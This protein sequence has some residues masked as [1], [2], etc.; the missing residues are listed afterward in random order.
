MRTEFLA[1]NTKK[2]AQKLAPWAELVVK[3]TG[4][5]RAFES[6]EDYKTFKNQK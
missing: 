4:G 6:Q 1:V 2:A 3:V 5:Y